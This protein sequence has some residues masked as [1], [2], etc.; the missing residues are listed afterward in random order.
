MAITAQQA[1]IS[2]LYAAYF[3]RASDPQGLSYWV[4]H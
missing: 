2:A 3:N 4:G 1:A